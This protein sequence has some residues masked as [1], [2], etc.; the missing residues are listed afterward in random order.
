MVIINV[1]MVHLYSDGVNELY[2]DKIF[3]D[4]NGDVIRYDGDE[5]E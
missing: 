3:I 1:Y 4:R 5:N 2:N